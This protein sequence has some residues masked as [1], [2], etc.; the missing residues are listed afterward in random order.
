MPQ[1]LLVEVQILPFKH[2]HYTMLTSMLSDQKYPGIDF[3]TMKSLPKIGYIATLRN[4]PIAAG[5]LRRIEGGYGQL[6]TFATNPHFGKLIRNE[7]LNKVVDSLINEAK[8][9]KLLGLI[10]FTG[11][12][13]IITRAKDQGFQIINQTI[14][15]LT[16][17]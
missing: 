1:D 14:I 5:F 3:V 16:L 7:G 4:Q 11:D 12:L 6:D 15:G 13:G 8:E 17:D 10:G 2:K 9:L